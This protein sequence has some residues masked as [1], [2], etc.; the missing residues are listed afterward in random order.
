MTATTT[1]T[2]E[3]AMKHERVQSSNI[4]SIAYDPD[5][6]CLQALFKNDA[7]YEY[8]GVQPEVAH[9]LRTATSVGQYLNTRIKGHYQYVKLSAEEAMQ[10]R[11]SLKGD[12]PASLRER[13]ADLA[14]QQ[15]SD[16]MRYFFGKCYYV[17]EQGAEESMLV[18]GDYV[19]NLQHQMATVYAGLT[20]EEKE[21]DRAEAD[22]VLALLPSPWSEAASKHR[23]VLE[24]LAAALEEPAATPAQQESLLSGREDAL[25]QFVVD[26]VRTLEQGQQ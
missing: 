20:E 17:S 21:F 4:D 6:Y 22:K 8:M 24:R 25:L 19:E 15:W 1:L 13:L 2:M 7:L 26:A 12:T 16:W 5:T 14:H 18:P 9:E 10:A 3:N 11:A 23:A